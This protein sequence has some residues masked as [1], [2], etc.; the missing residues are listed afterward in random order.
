MKAWGF[1]GIGGSLG[2]CGVCGESF[3]ADVIKDLCGMDSRIRQFSA[4]DHDFCAHDP[5]CFDKLK[6]AVTADGKLDC[7]KLPI[8]PLRAYALGEAWPPTA[9]EEVK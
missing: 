6:E 2:T 5:E 4:G 8:G 3:A 7:E 1:P 9:L